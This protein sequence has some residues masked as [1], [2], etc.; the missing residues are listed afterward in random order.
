LEVQAAKTTFLGCLTQEGDMRGR[1]YVVLLMLSLSSLACRGPA[2][3]SQRPS[4]GI[5]DVERNKAVVRRWVEEAHNKRNLSVVD[6]TYTADYRGHTSTGD[7]FDIEQG[8]MMEQTFQADF[9]KHS[10]SI[11][12]L[13]GEGDRVVSR[14][15][16]S[17]THK[18]GKPVVFSGVT[19]SRFSNG[20]I[21]EEWMA[22]DNLALMTQLGVK[23]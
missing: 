2:S 20:K 9:P 12:D 11:D 6:E 22:M 19:I 13:I 5:D 8:R 18:S 21:V 16:V 7:S 1:F 14:W 4:T 15:T 17:A 23:P 3:E 10:V